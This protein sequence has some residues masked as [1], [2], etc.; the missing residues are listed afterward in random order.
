MKPPNRFRVYPVRA[1]NGRI[2]GWAVLE[3]VPTGTGHTHTWREID[4][5]RTQQAAMTI[6]HLAARRR[7]K[8]TRS[9]R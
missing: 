7:R 4:Y 3:R 5:L 9:F 8:R 2:Q 6:A 1:A